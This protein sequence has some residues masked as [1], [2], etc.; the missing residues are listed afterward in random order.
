MKAL[1]IAVLLLLAPLAQAKE[2]ILP[3]TE[4]DAAAL[5]GKTV[6]V[7]LHKRAD[8]VAMTAGK[9][10]FALFGVGAMRSAGND[11]VDNNGVTDPAILIREHLAAGLAAAY[12]AQ[13]APVDTVAATSI[14]PKDIAAAHKQ[15]N[16][17]LDVRSTGWMYAYY[18]TNWDRYWVGYGV[19]VKLIDTQDG[20]EVSNLA[21]NANTNQHAVHPTRDE[22]QGN[23]AALLKAV[24]T[25][26][27]WNCLQ[28]LAVQQFHLSEGKVPATPAEFVDPLTASQNKSRPAPAAPVAAEA[29]QQ[30]APATDMGAASDAGSNASAAPAAP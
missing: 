21:C 1:S 26:L 2:K 6:A 10:S 8:F 25:S 17:V 19:Q 13:V 4:A 14:K 12:G 24:T 18:P 3:L 15:A 29:P 27:G 9:A 20:R 30:P 7:S 23:G 16:Y 11:L 5:S 28:L 22:L